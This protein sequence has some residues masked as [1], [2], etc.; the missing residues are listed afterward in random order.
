MQ[1]TFSIT[2]A[3]IL[4]SSGGVLIKAI[5]LDAYQIS[6]WRSLFAIFT[7]FAIVK[8]RHLTFD[9]STIIASFAYAFTLIFFVIA[10]KLTTA[11]NAILLQYTAPIYVLLFSRFLL[12]E[13]VSKTQLVLVIVALAGMVI[14]F[15]DSISPQG[16]KGN[17]FAIM[18]GFF[19][20]LFLLLSRKNRREHPIDAVLLGNGLI[21]LIC[22]TI[23]MYGAFHDPRGAADEYI[24]YGYAISTADSVMVA[25]LGILQIGIPYILFTRGIK[26]VRALDASLIAM[27]EPVLNPVWVFLFVGESPSLYTVTGGLIILA[28]VAL[29]SV[30]TTRSLNIQFFRGV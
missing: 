30:F 15:L 17:V 23:M 6:F 11:A 5:S 29:Q 13:T 24:L 1:G 2:L 19:F 20:G 4:W 21:V 9:T 27:L 25:F 10:T 22:S 18:S 7:I 26:F 28:A 8:P 12:N 14:F 16:V 3:A